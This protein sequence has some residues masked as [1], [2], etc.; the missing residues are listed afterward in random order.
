MT[1][2]RPFEGGNR[3]QYDGDPSWVTAYNGCRNV[4]H[5]NDDY[6]DSDGDGDVANCGWTNL[7]EQ[8]VISDENLCT[9]ANASFGDSLERLS[10]YTG[11]SMCYEYMSKIHI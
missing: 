1:Q 5:G 6:D 3:Q 7:W 10:S 8:D 2:F 11:I 9:H 4:L